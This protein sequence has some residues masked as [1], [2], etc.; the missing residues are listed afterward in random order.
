MGRKAVVVPFDDKNS[1]EEAASI[2]QRIVSLDD[3]VAVIGHF[4]SNMNLVSSPI[5]QEA[6]MLNITPSASH[7]AITD[8]GDYIFRNNSLVFVEAGYA[9][10]I[11]VDDLGKKNIGMISVM[12]D[13]GTSTSEI[14]KDIIEKEYASKGA[15]LVAHEQVLVGS[16][17]Y[18]PAVTKLLA[19]GA[20][21][22]ICVGEYGVVAP[23][24]RQ[25]KQFDPN[26]E[27]VCFSNAYSKQ[28]I[29]LGGPA[30]DGVRF[31]ASFFAGS[32][33]PKVRSFVDNFVERY[34]YV[35]NNSMAQSYDTMG[36]ILEAIV[37]TKSTDSAALRDYIAQIEYDGVTGLTRF[38]ERGDATKIYTKVMIKNGDFVEFK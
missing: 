21:V 31:P 3:I 12:T 20:D 19:A 28:L 36:M 10:E 29:E 38:D 13:W 14:V 11:A 8:I 35:P 4:S 25:Y 37:A 22:V 27:I 15:K 7:P 32:T 9:V 33:D 1:G 24:T 16:D 5:F 2:A 6:G 17:D 23:F 26:I 30:V 34:G 18:S